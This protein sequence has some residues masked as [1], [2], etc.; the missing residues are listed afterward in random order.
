MKTKRAIQA[1]K[2]GSRAANLICRAQR[3]ARGT[4]RRSERQFEFI[5]M[6]S[7]RTQK[8]WISRP[9]GPSTT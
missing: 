3:P 8:V 5:S 1:T 7:V 4:N 9:C 6:V 2:A